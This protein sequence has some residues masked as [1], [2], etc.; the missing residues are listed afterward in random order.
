MFE[1]RARAIEQEAPLG[2][3]EPSGKH[4]TRRFEKFAVREVRSGQVR[5]SCDHI[6]IRICSVWISGRPLSSS[7]IKA[8]MLNLKLIVNAPCVLSNFAE[9]R[10]PEVCVFQEFQMRSSDSEVLT[11]KN[12]NLEQSV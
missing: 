2:Q 1:S 12:S 5:Y 7:A 3:L 8:C 10:R 11:S 6:K 4:Q 9:V